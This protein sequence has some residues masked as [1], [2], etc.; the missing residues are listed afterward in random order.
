MRGRQELESRMIIVFI[1]IPKRK[2]WYLKMILIRLECMCISSWVTTRC[3]W[4]LKCLVCPIPSTY[5]GIQSCVKIMMWQACQLTTWWCGSLSPQNLT[6]WSGPITRLA[7][8]LSWVHQKVQLYGKFVIGLCHLPPQMK[9]QHG[10]NEKKTFIG[11]NS[12]SFECLWCDM[13]G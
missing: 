10:L 8:D 9:N 2:L 5:V 1:V 3:T 13:C 11:K 4:I 7:S 12:L 6:Q